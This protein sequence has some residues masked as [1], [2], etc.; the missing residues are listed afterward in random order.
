[1]VIAC[2]LMYRL[3]RLHKESDEANAAAAVYT[4]EEDG[5]GHEAT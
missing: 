2:L 5:G 3:C 4:H 1:M